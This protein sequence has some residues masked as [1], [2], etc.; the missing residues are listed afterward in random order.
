MNKIKEIEN[1]ENIEYG[2][3]DIA[4]RNTLK[5]DNE[6]LNFF[7][8]IWDEEVDEICEFLNRNNIKEFTISSQ[9]TGLIP[10]LNHLE[11]KGFKVA[12][13][14]MINTYYESSSQIPAII[15]KSI[16]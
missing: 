13:T 9:F 8:I 16:Q 5:S 11:Q 10:L 14:K 4:Y 15:L 3:I 2:T 7:D 1:K 12:G 6:M